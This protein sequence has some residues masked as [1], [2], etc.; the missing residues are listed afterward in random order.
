MLH[1][2]REQF[3]VPWEPFPSFLNIQMYLIGDDSLLAQPQLSVDEQEE[4]KLFS[5]KVTLRPE[6][7]HQLAGCI[8]V[9]YTILLRL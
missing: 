5:R 9:I 2:S 3:F 7:R 6:K 1:E 8:A 4:P